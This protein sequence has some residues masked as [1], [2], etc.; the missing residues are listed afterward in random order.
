MNQSEKQKIKAMFKPSMEKVVMEQY[1]QDG[2]VNVKTNE[3]QPK[4]H[5]LHCG[6]PMHVVLQKYQWKSLLV[7]TIIIPNMRISVCSK[8]PK[9]HPC[10]ISGDEAKRMEAFYMAVELRFI[11]MIQTKNFVSTHE[12]AVLL[13]VRVRDMGKTNKNLRSNFLIQYK[14]SDGTVLWLR[15]S[16]DRYKRTGDGR[17]DIRKLA[18]ET[19][20]QPE[21]GGV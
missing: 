4:M 8:A 16:I 13:G 21:H 14:M 17:F 19:L 6:K 12:A 7:G 20:K 9:K 10:Y 5:C 18:C 15:Q 11:K 2:T 3:S 1:V